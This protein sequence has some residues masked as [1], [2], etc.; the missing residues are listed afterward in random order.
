MVVLLQYTTV[1]LYIIYDIASFNLEEI[2]DER[3]ETA[4][5][6]HRIVF[7]LYLCIYYQ[8][9]IFVFQLITKDANNYW[10]RETKNHGACNSG[11]EYR[12]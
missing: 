12:R 4:K 2:E 9:D 1:N 3:E 10:I 7:Y 11:T 5:N 8:I 6:F